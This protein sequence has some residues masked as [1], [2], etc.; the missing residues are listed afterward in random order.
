[1][2]HCTELRHSCVEAK[3]KAGLGF[4]AKPQAAY[5][6]NG[7]GSRAAS[8]AFARSVGSEAWRT[9]FE[10]SLSP[11]VLH[12]RVVQVTGL[13]TSVSKLVG[14]LFL[15]PLGCRSGWEFWEQSVSSKSFSVWAVVVS[16]LL[17]VFQEQR[18]FTVHVR[19]MLRYFPPF[20][21]VDF[22]RRSC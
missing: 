14:I 9:Y 19:R 2:S 5:I 17:R 12:V 22:P 3:P 8:S 20:L 13:G 6:R 15:V 16:P 7:S 21:T 18:D 11:R 4:R 1:M 10:G